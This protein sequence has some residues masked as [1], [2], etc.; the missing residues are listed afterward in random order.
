[1]VD[2]NSKNS[3]GPENLPNKINTTDQVRSSHSESRASC[4]QVSPEEDEPRQQQND[5]TTIFE[6][7]HGTVSGSAE[8]AVVTDRNTQKS[9]AA[10]SDSIKPIEVLMQPKDG[11]RHS[12]EQSMNEYQEYLARRQIAV[13]RKGEQSWMFQ[14]DA[15]E[16]YFGSIVE[17]AAAGKMR[18]SAIGSI[19]AIAAQ[20]ET[21][22]SG[23]TAA[24]E[25]VR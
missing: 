20:R 11:E 3:S 10:T 9:A 14:P 8:R 6:S 7:Q 24:D 22:K 12:S 16:H 2:E 25:N 18:D 5:L 19:L 13:Q 4:S 23:H 21:L 1:M 15:E 17:P